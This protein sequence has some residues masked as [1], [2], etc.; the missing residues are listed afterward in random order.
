MSLYK[1]CAS[2]CFWTLERRRLIGFQLEFC[3]P[4]LSKWIIKV[5][6]LNYYN[7]NKFAQKIMKTYLISL[8]HYLSK[9]CVEISRL[10]AEDTS[11]NF[12]QRT[13][14]FLTQPDPK[15]PPPIS[16][17]RRLPASPLLTRVS[18]SNGEIVKLHLLNTC[19][20][21]GDAIFGILDF[22]GSSHAHACTQFCVS[23]I[24]EEVSKL[25]EKK[26]KK[27]GDK[28][29][30]IE[31]SVQATVAEVCLGLEASSFEIHVPECVTPSF[32]NNLS[33]SLQ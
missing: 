10:G 5:K 1:S 11:E 16:I 31:R 20:R 4:L 17:P 30:K 19:L 18:D 29:F 12:L 8:V 2:K 9:S 14:P 28:M 25:S 13:N 7:F 26:S 23:L 6:L 21:P 22:R 24:A 3:L 27:F 33:K 32:K 15:M